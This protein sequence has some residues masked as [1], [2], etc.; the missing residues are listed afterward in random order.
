[1]EQIAQIK[2]VIRRDGHRAGLLHLR[3]LGVPFETVY[4][5]LF[6]RMPRT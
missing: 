4:F 3:S 5:A 2:R 1:M 6:G